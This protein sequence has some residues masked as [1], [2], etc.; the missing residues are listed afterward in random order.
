MTAAC[1]RCTVT[2]A[3]SNASLNGNESSSPSVQLAVPCDA[4]VVAA[5]LRRRE[6]SSSLSASTCTS[7]SP[8][9]RASVS[10]GC[11]GLRSWVAKSRL[12]APSTFASRPGLLLLWWWLLS[13]LMLC[14]SSE[15]NASRNAVG[16]EALLAAVA[17]TGEAGSA[18][19]LLLRGT[20]GISGDAMETGGSARG[21]SRGRGL[22]AVNPD[23]LVAA[24][25]VVGVEFVDRD[26]LVVWDS[27]VAL[28]SL[29]EERRRCGAAS[30]S[31]TTLQ[32]ATPIFAVTRD[33][34]GK[35]QGER[36]TSVKQL[37]MAYARFFVFA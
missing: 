29:P 25:V 2:G 4:R 35:I 15:C 34:G 20:I 31:L 14:V 27:D 6:P 12:R 17:R 33:R 22:T 5:A 30:T 28:W 36:R 23:T 21:R 32:I 24:V 19:A 3:L 10:S 7:K 9:V 18:L 1:L 8:R 37:V 11:C 16:T 13:A 26:V